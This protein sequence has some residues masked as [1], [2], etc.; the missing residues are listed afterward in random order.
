VKDD[1]DDDD[2]KYL[3]YSC[4][5]LREKSSKIPER[6][7]GKLPTSLKAFKLKMVIFS[8]VF[9]NIFLVLR[10]VGLTLIR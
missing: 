2:E 1:D 7:I 5:K 3:P 10:Y 6:E 4:G 8:F 9:L